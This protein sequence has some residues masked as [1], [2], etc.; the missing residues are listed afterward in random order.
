MLVDCVSFGL[1]PRKVDGFLLERT[2]EVGE[3]NL[4]FHFPIAR[5]LGRFADSPT[6]T[7][8]ER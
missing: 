8:L 7:G 6:F 1:V 5:N 3:K 4:T 2:V